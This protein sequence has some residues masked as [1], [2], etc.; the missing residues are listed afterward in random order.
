VTA[1][2]SAARLAGLR[3]AGW[4]LKRP[5]M[6]RGASGREGAARRILMIRPDH[7]GDMLLAAPSGRLLAEALPDAEI[8][9]LVGPWAAEVAR[10]SGNDGRVRTCEFPGFTRRPKRSLAEPYTVLLKEARRLRQNQY[11]AALIS[12][13]DHW[14]GALLAASAGIPRRFGFAVDACRPF[15]TDTLPPPSGHVLLASQNL[16]RLAADRLGG[17]AGRAARLFDPRFDVSDAERTHAQTLIDRFG[18]RAWPLVAI[19]PGSGAP[20]KNWPAE[21]WPEVVTSL[22]DRQQARVILTAG[23]DEQD[24][25]RA[26]ASGVTGRRPLLAGRTTLGGLAAIFAACDLVLGG[27]S[28]PLHIAA[29][30]GTPTVRLYGPTS[31][32]IFGPWGDPARHRVLQA[33]LPCQPCDNFADPPCRAIE[34]PSCLYAVTVDEVVAAATDLLSART[35]RRVSLPAGSA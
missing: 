16:A 21:R 25:V 10:R 23:P 24:L 3:A 28:G 12:R 22:Q 31:V 11:D 18:G 5:G 20:A 32:G 35:T 34:S 1:G 9:W 29:A 26:I 2:R 30:V 15:L 33:S 4:V 13:P 14:W 8:D 6:S 17:G 7:V 19:H 27:D